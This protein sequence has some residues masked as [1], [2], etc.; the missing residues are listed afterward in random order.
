M[1]L[2]EIKNL[3][4]IYRIDDV[5]TQALRGVSFNVAKGEFIAII[6]PSGSGKST[7]LHMLGFLDTPTEGDYL[8][9][10]KSIKD[11]SEEE[12]A[13]VR[14]KKMGFVFQSFNLL[15]RNS[16][17]D[18]VMLPLMYSDIPEKEWKKRG[19]DAIE[20]VGL[21]H[22]RDHL[23]AKLSGGEKQ[24]TAI[25]R[26]LINNPEIIFADEPTGNLDT[27]TG[28]TIM[29]IFNDLNRNKKHTLIL[30]T[31]E[32]EVAQY[33]DRIIQVRD[34]LIEYDINSKNGNG[35]GN[36]NVLKKKAQ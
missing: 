23:T 7:L 36:G 1:S 31:H 9:E 22:R 19:E 32:Q 17:I 6:G 5:E 15:P 3:K 12:Q 11:F 10:G 30:I 20:A 35:N 34:G 18:N 27:K 14:N 21:S 4:K 16:V 25:A 29:E 24:R 8:F 26:A 28:D 13:L 2:I 33:A